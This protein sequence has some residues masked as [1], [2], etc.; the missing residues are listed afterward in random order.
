MAANR[1]FYHCFQPFLVILFIW[2]TVLI[3]SSSAITCPPDQKI[4]PCKC[5]SRFSLISCDNLP[6]DVN[7]ASIFRS[8]SDSLLKSPSS[9]SQSSVTFDQFKLV[10]S[11]LTELGSGR[12][13]N[14]NADLFSGVSFKKINILRNKKLKR[15]DENAF[16]ASANITTELIFEDNPVLGSETGDVQELFRLANSFTNLQVLHITECDIRQVPD[17]A[18]S[19]PQPALREIMMTDNRISSIGARPFTV[20]S[21][22]ELL[23]LDGNQISRL[24]VDA[25]NLPAN[26]LHPKKQIRILLNSNAL[27][28]TSLPAGI[29]ARLRRPTY[30]NLDINK[31]TTVP[32]AVF[33]SL[34]LRGSVLSLKRNPLRCDCGMR[35]LSDQKLLYSSKAP[36]DA[37]FLLRHYVCQSID[38]DGEEVE[39][40]EAEET[41]FKHCAKEKLQS[42]SKVHCGAGD[43]DPEEE[44]NC[45]TGS[46]FGISPSFLKTV[47]SH[48]FFMPLIWVL[49][50]H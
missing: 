45:L 12:K 14:G 4:S 1:K 42:T 32:E 10:N 44:H 33:G 18:F 41:D 22:L 27:N 8:L 28:D 19:R 35:W 26:R 24:S 16:S 40:H 5:I 20:L 30:L 15:I 46:V 11:A 39:I 49:F 25:F 6:A 17:G 9:N 7:I 3:S 29:F 36:E 23:N 13:G 21:G 31:L 37:Y 38:K 50:L 2:I 47:I 48:L 34:A 43:L